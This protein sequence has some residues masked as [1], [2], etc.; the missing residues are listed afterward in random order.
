MEEASGDL[1]S[2]SYI[3]LTIDMIL[4]NFVYFNFI[5]QAEYL[6]PARYELLLFFS[7]STFT[8]Q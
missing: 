1:I 3:N 7:A 4:L 6:K 8:I 5:T 2:K